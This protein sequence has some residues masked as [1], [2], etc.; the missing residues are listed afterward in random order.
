MVIVEFED[1][2][3]DNSFREIEIEVESKFRDWLV[4]VVVP[5]V[6]R[7]EGDVTNFILNI[8]DGKIVSVCTWYIASNV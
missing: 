4:E 5:V 7:V 1:L 8:R 3:S 6:K 2:Q